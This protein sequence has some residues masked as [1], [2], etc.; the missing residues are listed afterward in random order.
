VQ[1]D[2]LSPIQRG[3]LAEGTRDYVDLRLVAADVARTEKLVDPEE[4]RRRTL[5]ALRPLLEAGWIQAGHTPG[6]RHFKP[7]DLSPGS[8]LARIDEEWSALGR[9]INVWDIVL[10]VT[11][12]EGKRALRTAE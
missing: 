11:T 8:M 12:P 2:A 9:E 1:P 6:G 3:I 7:W 10:F 5:D 4:M